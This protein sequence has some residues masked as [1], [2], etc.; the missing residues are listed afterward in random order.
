MINGYVSGHK[1]RVYVFGDIGGHADLFEAALND[2]GVRDGAIPQDRIIVQVG[3]LVDRGPDSD[4]VVALVDKFIRHPSWVQ[5]IG[6]HEAQHLGGPGFGTP[7]SASAPSTESIEIIRGWDREGY[8]NLAA[9]FTG[10]GNDFLVSHA[11]LPFLFWEGMGRPKAEEIPSIL[12]D[13]PRDVTFAAGE[14]LNGY[15]TGAAGPVWASVWNELIVP[16]Y[17]AVSTGY[18][19]APPFVQV[20]G[21]STLYS[22]TRA[23]GPMFRGKDDMERLVDYSKMLRHSMFR[24]D[25]LEI[26]QCDPALGKYS[27]FQ[28]APYVFS[29]LNWYVK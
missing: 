1:M 3:D 21:H 11:G 23:K 5:L 26:V 9:A 4:G 16:W 7:Q 6:N 24:Y 22:W 19:D 12:E 18:I 13:L 2:I 29:A 25:G 20:H 8:L 15:P 10:D 17:T 28:P 14:M 27:S